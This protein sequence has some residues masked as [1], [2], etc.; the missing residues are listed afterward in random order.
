[1]AWIDSA[2]IIALI[3]AQDAVDVIGVFNES[4]DPALRAGFSDS[5]NVC[6]HADTTAALD[7]QLRCSRLARVLFPIETDGRLAVFLAIGPRNGKPDQPYSPSDISVMRE[8]GGRIGKLLR[9]S[10]ALSCAEMEFE[11][12]RS[13]QDRLVSGRAPCIPDIECSGQCERS[14]DLG[15]DFFEFVG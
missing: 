6:A 1:L 10:G 3:Q 11:T 14:G 5:I 12:V 9:S 7:S 13:I 15:G 8:L 4:A 2:W